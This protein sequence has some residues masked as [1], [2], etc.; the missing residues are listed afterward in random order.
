MRVKWKNNKALNPQL[1]LERISAGIKKM[2]DG[3]LGFDM[4][5]LE[6]ETLLF[7][8]LDFA[9]DYSNHNALYLLKRAVRTCAEDGKLSKENFLQAINDE[10]RGHLGT[11]E[12]LFV[13]ST[14]ISMT[15]GFPINPIILGG[16]KIECYPQGFPV[17]YNGR[18]TFL[19][20]WKYQDP[21][22]TPG[23]CAVLV[24]V[25]R[26][27]WLDAAEQALDALDL[28][29]GIFCYIYNA[30]S[31]FSLVGFKARI[32]NKISLGGM[33]CI[34]NEDGTLARDKQFWF[35]QRYEKAPPFVISD[36]Q[37]EI[38]ASRFNE[39]VDHLSRHRDERLIKK[40]FIRYVRA[41]DNYDKNTSVMHL[42]SVLE[43]LAGKDGY[44]AESI[45]RRCS[46]IHGERAFHQ[47]VLEHLR[48]YRNSSVHT[49]M[50]LESPDWH[51]FQLQRY[52]RHLVH[53]YLADVDTFNT[54]DEANRFLDLADSKEKLLYEIDVRQKALEFF[55]FDL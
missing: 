42:W 45:V 38:G 43:S 40:S 10:V 47:Q 15:G 1:I 44:A 54:I 31:E 28:V 13:L 39:M 32:E 17:E 25:K 48:E 4:N 33:H 35:E 9:E 5:I 29:R 30:E 2:P 8:M 23:Q 53:F 19:E 14:S 18:N 24:S 55:R 20:R 12:Q 49:G 6:L 36:G 21:P 27:N 11:R 52:F 16:A 7:T 26:K 51:C 3:T 50:H 37:K 34:H 46:F 41:I 22:F